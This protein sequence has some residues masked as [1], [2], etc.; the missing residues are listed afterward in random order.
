MPSFGVSKWRC[1]NPNLKPLCKKPLGS[2]SNP[3]KRFLG[4]LQGNMPQR[5]ATVRDPGAGLGSFPGHFPVGRAVLSTFI[6][7]TAQT[8]I[9]AT[10]LLHEQDPSSCTLKPGPALHPKA[11][12]AVEGLISIHNNTNPHT[13][14][15]SRP[16]HHHPNQ[17]PLTAI[18]S[19]HWRSLHLPYRL[20]LYVHVYTHYM[21]TC[22][23]RL[24]HNMILGS[25]YI[26]IGIILPIIIIAITIIITFRNHS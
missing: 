6:A 23:N 25:I 1:Q 4:F 7:T 10:Q 15:L 26:Y 9:I 11:F 14:P 8:D 17:R 16:L 18:H 22:T 13:T 12:A 20:Y 19:Y 24:Q 21:L 3:K 2:D 5:T